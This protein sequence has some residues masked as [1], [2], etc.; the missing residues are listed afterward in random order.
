MSLIRCDIS[1]G[2]KLPKKSKYIMDI[3]FLLFIFLN[4][5]SGLP[6]VRSKPEGVC[7]C[8]HLMEDIG[9]DIAQSF[10]WNLIV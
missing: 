4:N 5:T 2:S 10:P 3:R 6:R 7:A 9:K 8:V 1:E